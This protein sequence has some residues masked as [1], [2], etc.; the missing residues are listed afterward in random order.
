M[1]GCMEGELD[2]VLA[3]MNEKAGMKLVDLVLPAGRPGGA[4]TLRCARRVAHIAEVGN[5]PV[6]R[7]IA[8][9]LITRSAQPQ[10]LRHI[11][12]ERAFSLLGL[13]E[14]AVAEARLENGGRVDA[15]RDVRQGL[16]AAH[17]LAVAEAR[18]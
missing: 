18:P 10:L 1:A 13:V 6:G 11:G 14:A 5:R 16:R 8:D 7:V 3:P 17:N 12:L 2:C 4:L 9:R 15:V